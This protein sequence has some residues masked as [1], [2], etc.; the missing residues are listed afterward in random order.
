MHAQCIQR[1]DGRTSLVPVRQVIVFQIK[2]MPAVSEV[3]MN[4]GKIQKH[5]LK[6]VNKPPGHSAV[7]GTMN[8]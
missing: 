4:A 6:P 1:I 8:T 2:G 7:N 3:H 5:Q